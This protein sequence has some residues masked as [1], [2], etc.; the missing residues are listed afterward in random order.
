VPSSDTT[1]LKVL[2]IHWGFSLGGVA[3]YAALIDG[4]GR[5]A[6]VA[7]LH[8]CVLGRN[9]P[10]DEVTLG[11]LDARRIWLRS[12]VDLSWIWK[13]R[14]EITRI[15]PDLLMT[16]GFNGY[17]VA[18][19]AN[20]GV[21]RPVPVVCSYHGLY[22]ATTP[23]R[24][25]VA[26]AF[27]RFAEYFLRRR[28][29]GIATVAEFTRRYLVSRS[30][31]EWKIAVIYNGLKDAPLPDGERSAVR[32]EWGA[33]EGEIVI[34]SASRLDPMKG[35]AHLIDA[36]ARLAPRHRDMRLVILGRGTVEDEL[37]RQSAAHGLDGQVVFAGYRAD[38]KR[39]LAGFDVFALPSLAENHSIALLEA[40]RAGKAIV[41]TDV[42]GNTES[43]HDGREALVV[44][45]ADADSLALALERLAADPDLRA[46][47]GDAARRRFC[48]EFTEDRM[49]EKTARWLIACGER[50]CRQGAR[51]QQ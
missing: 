2:S 33:G 46:R 26:P 47:L 19:V 13:V 29:L 6:T 4:V 35:V 11:D 44:P 30:V 38:I 25:L 28:A 14:R 45:P 15:R 21:R 9:W 49:V 22:H 7:M 48:A 5:Q 17:F 40:M 16:H 27:N 39:C 12:R 31:A 37:K 36:F 24:R 1:P 34:A 41:A 42:G 23:L 20:L 32:E 8:L 10:I 3:K 50:A 43:V 18:F 51:G